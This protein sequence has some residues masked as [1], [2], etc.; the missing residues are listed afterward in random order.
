MS[1]KLKLTQQVD[2]CRHGVL[3]LSYTWINTLDWLSLYIKNTCDFFSRDGSVVGDQHCHHTP[4]SLNTQCEMCHIKQ[5]QLILVLDACSPS[6]DGS[7][8]TAAL[9]TTASPGLTQNCWTPTN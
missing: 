9:Y 2:V 7:V 1:E 8:C 6:E 5:H 4:S 3:T